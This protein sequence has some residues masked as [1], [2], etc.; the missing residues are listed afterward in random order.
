MTVYNGEWLSTQTVIGY[1]K[2]ELNTYAFIEHPDYGDE[3]TMLVLDM[4]RKSLHE[5]NYW[6]LPDREDFAIDLEEGDALI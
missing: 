1:I 6:D 2:H 4:G 3:S 5:S